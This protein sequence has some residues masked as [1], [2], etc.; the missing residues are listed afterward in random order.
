VR[1]LL[2]PEW[3]VFSEEKKISTT[4]AEFGEKDIPNEAERNRYD[5]LALTDNRTLV[6]VELKRPNYAV[7][8]AEMMRQQVRQRTT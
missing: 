7:T 4:L 6:I 2:N 8:A 3:Q 5:F 1:R